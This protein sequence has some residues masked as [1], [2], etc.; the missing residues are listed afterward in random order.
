MIKSFSSIWLR[1]IKRLMKIQSE[2]ASQ[3]I[4]RRKKTTTGRK[5]TTTGRKKTTTASAQAVA[6]RHKPVAKVLNSAAARLLVPSVRHLRVEPRTGTG[7]G[8]AGTWT[9]SFFSAPPAA[10]ELVNHLVYGLYLPPAPR[11]APLPLV[12]MLHGCKQTIEDFAQGT[13]MNV[14][15]DR[16]GFAVL[17]PEQSKHAQAH[18]CWHWYD[19]SA[20][21]GAKE[22]ASIAALIEAIVAKHRMDPTR[23][24][25]AG[26]SAGAGMTALLA[27]RYPKLLAAIGLHSG[28]AFGEARTAGGA[29]SVMR[30]GAQGDP[31]ELVSAALDVAVH[32]GMPTLIVHGDAD[33]IVAQANADQLEVQFLKLNGALEAGGQL[34][35][36]IRVQTVETDTR[37]AADLST[38]SVI[39]S[40]ESGSM[41]PTQTASHAANSSAGS[42]PQ[43]LSRV[44]TAYSHMTQ[45]DYRVGNRV[46]VRACRIAGLAHGWSGGDDAFAFHTS[47][48]PDA[49]AL[50]WQFFREHRRK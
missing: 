31:V 36:A 50:M 22:A 30:R 43:A 29:L 12:V 32:P 16:N 5:K 1:G 42:T 9:R 38:R 15:A 8:P 7:T 6:G 37:T 47:R 13:R 4:K 10:G 23:V 2:H 24:Y 41:A 18:R 17:Y 11:S 40:N 45:R 44:R 34:A 33:G 48:G 21:A 46:I 20:G 35:R 19:E 14:L 39:A 49:S 27:M 26:M 3:L 25:V 28:V